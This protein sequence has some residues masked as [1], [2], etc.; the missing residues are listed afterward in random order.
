MLRIT[1]W[2]RMSRSDRIGAFESSI[3]IKVVELPVLVDLEDEAWSRE[4]VRRQMRRVCIAHDHGGE[5]VVLHFA[6]QVQS[7]E[8]LQVVEA[9][10]VLQV[11]HLVFEDEVEGRA[12]HAAE[13]H[14]FFGEA[15]DPQIDR[16]EA[17]ERT[18][19]ISTRGVEEVE[20][21]LFVK[22]GYWPQHVETDI[23]DQN[24]VEACR[25]SVGFRSQS[26]PD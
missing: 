7:V 15:T 9:V 10:A 11:L 14:D 23:I 4:H 3:S 25:Q 24:L 26:L 22:R 17:T 18:A 21:V 13:G 2:V 8:P 20:P 19:R 6:E 12:Q 16:I 5:G 1:S